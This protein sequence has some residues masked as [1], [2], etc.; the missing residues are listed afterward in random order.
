MKF[1]GNVRSHL[2]KHIFGFVIFMKL[3]VVLIGLLPTYVV[4]VYIAGGVI[5]FVALSILC[6]SIGYFNAL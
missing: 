6:K 2:M 3:G 4:H 5:L 1:I